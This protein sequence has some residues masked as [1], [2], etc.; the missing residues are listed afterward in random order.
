MSGA[1]LSDKHGGTGCAAIFGLAGLRLLEDERTLFRQAQPAGYILFARNIESPHQIKEL[2]SDLRSLSEFDPLIL[3]DQEGGRVARLRPPHWRAAPPAQRFGD[4]AQVDRAAACRAAALNAGLLAAELAAL[5]INVDCAPV[6]DLPVPGAHDI[7]GDRAFAQDAETIGIL[8]RRFCEGMIAA[9]VLPVIK[10]I[11]GHGR[12]TVDSHHDLPR[13]SSGLATLRETDFA[14]FRALSDMPLAMTAHIVYDAIDPDAPAT[15]SRKL[16][17]ETIR[18]EIGFDGL[19]MTDDLGMRALTGTPGSLGVSSL[20]AG[21]DLVLHCSG[22][23]T[24]M[25][26]LAE[27]CGAPSGEARTRIAR[28]MALLPAEPPAVDMAA[29]QDEL[30][31]LLPV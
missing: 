9:G 20:A 26:E 1:S 11:P 14:P 13:V 3:I 7:I 8:G 30:A 17:Q 21:C 31:S 25:R 19:L 10:H 16:V 2:T 27:A 4:L 23:L 15:L 29:M 24:E 5:G 28:A 12:A 18:G 22:N 6:L